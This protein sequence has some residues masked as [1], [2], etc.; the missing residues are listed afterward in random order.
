VLIRNITLIDA[1]KGICESR[2]VTLSN[3]LIY[4]ITSTAEKDFPKSLRGLDQS[5]KTVASIAVL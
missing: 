3:G 5:D 2:S 1:N 4:R